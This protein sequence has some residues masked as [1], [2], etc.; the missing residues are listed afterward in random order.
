[1]E[2]LPGTKCTSAQL[3]NVAPGSLDD[4]NHHVRLKPA[5]AS[6]RQ[7]HLAPAVR[8][9]APRLASAGICRHR[10]AA[11]PAEGRAERGRGKGSRHLLVC[12]PWRIGA[13]DI[14][15]KSRDTGCM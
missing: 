6:D 13:V 1:M 12:A 15:L 5:R 10:E 4:R 14:A 2:L 3:Y 7:C 8:E 11:R 9:T